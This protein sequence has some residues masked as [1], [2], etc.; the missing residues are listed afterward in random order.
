MLDNEKRDQIA[1]QK[2]SLIAP[3]LN[4][5][6]DNQSE[7]FIEITSKAIDMPYYGM[8]KYSPKTLAGWLN[9][10]RCSGIEALKPGF[11]SDRGKSRKIDEALL[12]KIREK[13]MQK[14]RINSSM[15]YEALVKD[16]VILPEKV[17]M[18]TF[19][20]FLAANPDLTA[21]KN[22]DEEQEVKRFAH[23]YINELWQT[24]LMYGP[25]LKIGKTKKQTY[26]IAFIDDA[27]RYIPYSMWSFS[28]DFSTLR[29][30]LKEA[31]A[32]KGVPSMI[33]TDNGKIFRSSQL[34]MVCA[35]MGCSLLHAKPFQASSKGKIERYFHTVRMR[36]LSQIDPN[37]IKDVDELNL[38]YW[39]WLEADYHQKVHS[40]L[41]IS[42][43]DFFMSQSERIR[44]FPNPAMLD[45]YFLLKVNRKV[46]HDATLS[47]DTIL[48]ETDLCF[49][50]SRMEVRYDPE[51]LLNPNT[52]ILL[53][54]EGKKVGEA[55]QVNFHDNAHAKRKGPG[56][57][58]NNRLVNLKESS[59]ESIAIVS[60]SSNH[61]SFTSISKAD[62]QEKPSRDLSERGDC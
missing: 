43:L 41:K 29:V 21:A 34:Q 15:L 17:S 40:E 52:P 14:P 5:Q 6:V 51:W 57:P 61:I 36:F 33:Y 30:I 27:S 55:R 48:Y 1:L 18:A 22:P 35:G 47:L 24:D 39:Q 62:S 60:K 56:R 16:G 49:A 7:Y 45:E 59:Q 13:R 23:Q 31:V 58:V 44:L 2:F 8:R 53:Y 32:R 25:Y 37:E 42:P 20:R 38:L 26:L 50:N 54:H 3:V 10:Y 11:R 4:G 9:D 12:E 19:Y 28:Q 46:N